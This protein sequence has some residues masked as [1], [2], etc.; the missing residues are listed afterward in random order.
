[1]SSAILVTASERVLSGLNAHHG[2][3]HM[4]EWPWW[5]G[6]IHI[7]YPI[8]FF[9]GVGVVVILLWRKS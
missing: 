1:M 9:V 6:P 4:T 2:D 7:A 5:P 8:L 3:Y